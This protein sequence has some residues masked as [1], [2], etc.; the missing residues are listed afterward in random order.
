M[1]CSLGCHL[2]ADR[3]SWSAST[4]TPGLGSGQVRRPAPPPRAVAWSAL[5]RERMPDETLT[6]EDTENTELPH[7][8]TGESSRVGDRRREP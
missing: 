4:L 3:H 6:T 8:E 7:K 5:A 1:R 2:P